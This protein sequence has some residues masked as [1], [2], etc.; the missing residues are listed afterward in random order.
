MSIRN[1]NHNIYPYVNE[2][3]KQEIHFLEIW[4]NGNLTPK[5]ALRSLP[6]FD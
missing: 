2:N 3:E 5:E 6:E 1:A 4:T